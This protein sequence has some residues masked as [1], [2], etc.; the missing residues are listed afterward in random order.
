MKILLPTRL[1]RFVQL[2]MTLASLHA[3]PLSGSFSIVHC[4]WKRT[5]RIFSDPRSSQA[6][7]RMRKGAGTASSSP[8]RNGSKDLMLGSTTPHHYNLDWKELKKAIRIQI[9]TPLA[10]I[11]DA[12]AVY[13]DEAEIVTSLKKPVDPEFRKSFVAKGNPPR[14]STGSNGWHI[15]CG[16]TISLELWIL[17]RDLAS[18]YKS[19]S[20]FGFSFRG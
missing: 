12:I 19:S 16:V 20:F 11:Y 6:S 17:P 5:H 13:S 4:K 3:S 9:N 18:S 7:K 1:Q 10:S 2:S 8:K 15:P 14:S